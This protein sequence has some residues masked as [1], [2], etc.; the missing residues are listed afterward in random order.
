MYIYIYCAYLQTGI[1]L[2]VVVVVVVVVIVVVV[3]V[4]MFIYLVQIQTVASFP[5]GGASRQIQCNLFLPGRGLL[6]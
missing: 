5:N 6:V 3:V 2:V 4:K 1:L